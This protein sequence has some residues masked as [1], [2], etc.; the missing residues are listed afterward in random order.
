MVPTAVTTR[1]EP[2]VV[3]L[4]RELEAVMD[5]ARAVSSSL[6]IEELLPR[7]VE[8]TT[9]LMNAD[10]STLFIVDEARGELWSKVIQGERPQRIQLRVGE[11]IAGW[12]A[13]H[14][15]AVNLIDAYGDARF[16]KTWDEKSGY[17]TRSLLCVPIRNKE[18][19]VVAVIQCLNKQQRAFDVEDELLLQCIGGQ[20]AVAIE[21]AFLYASLLE[22]NRALADAEGRVRKA[23]AELEVLY[24]VERQ[25][26][27]AH[28]LPGMIAGVLERVQSLM[29]VEVAALLLVNDAGAEVHARYRDATQ[30]CSRTL[31]PRSAQALLLRARFPILRTA[32]AGGGVADLLLPDASGVSARET[33]SAPLS[34]GR[35]QIGILQVVNRIEARDDE[36]ALL[37]LLGLV[38]GQLARGLV[39]GR[40]R[41]AG[42]RAERLALLGHSVGAILHDLRTPLTAVGGYVELMTD[43]DTREVRREHAARVGRALEHMETMTQEVLAFAR[44][45]REVLIGR[46]YLDRFISEVREMLV[47]ELASFGIQLEIDVRYDGAARFDAGKLKRVIFNLARNAGQSMG[48]GGGGGGGSGSGGKFRWTI[49]R[50]GDYLVFECAD[51]GPGIPKDMEGRLFESFATH[52]K[53]G[54]TGLGL[55]MAKKIVDA[56]CGQ[57]SARSTPGHGATFRIEIPI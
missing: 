4:R 41:E 12:V 17:R 15:H 38:A 56:H 45:Q 35:S 14:G 44:G 2:P 7:I 22:K 39:V 18:G 1:S 3:R 57:I 40:E 16:D 54:G 47:P 49:D 25:I 51:T 9:Q 50:T 8:R 26:A 46:V 53:V 42:Q 23:H 52:G 27:A 30:L 11:G 21:N 10:R 32:D 5:I 31:E 6:D 24:E 37:R 19:R 29:K 33:C 48:G 13:Q 28:D 43:E 55:A 34:D 36:E 20:C